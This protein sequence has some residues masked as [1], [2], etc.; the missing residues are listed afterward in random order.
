MSEVR[1]SVVAPTYNEADNVKTLIERLS[2][3]LKDIDHEI[4]IAD[5]NSPD[6]TW[7]IA[8]DIAKVNPRVRSLRRME[9]R[10]L[11]PA[12]LDAFNIAK[13]KYLAVI[14]ADLQHDDSI[15]PQMLKEIEEQNHGI[16]I[17]SRYTKGGG[18]KGWAASRLFISRCANFTTGLLLKRRCSDLMSGYFMI[19]AD[20]YQGLADKLKPR[21][22]KILMDIL[23]NVPKDKSIGEVGY[24]FKPRGAGTSK[25]D[26]RVIFQFLVS[27]YELSMGRYVPLKF[28]KFGVVGL[29]G[30]AVN[31]LVIFLALAF[32]AIDKRV[33][34]IAGI[35][36]SMFSNFII[37]NLWTF[38]NEAKDKHIGYKL[39]Q[40]YI[41]C[42][43]GG[44]IQYFV[45]MAAYSYF[46][47]MGELW[48]IRPIY[49]GS[50][51][52]IGIAAIWNY[53]LNALITWREKP[54]ENV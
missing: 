8:E 27:L 44:V 26:N 29:S 48:F 39:L 18:I 31:W 50:T 54:Q 28:V 10:G 20:T 13:G 11:Y 19:G 16:V 46:K 22:F 40:F 15:L 37:N 47:P 52:G 42:L 2:N 51:C 25:L 14:D 33:A 41:I 30:V 53:V 36:I 24:V 49:L 35:L 45:T 9:N 6:E 3:T 17:G 7:K 4:I 34:V 43:V 12:V 38:A 32:T 23:Q 1:L 5:D 21:G